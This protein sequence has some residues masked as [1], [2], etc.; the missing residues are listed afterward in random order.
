MQTTLI[1]THFPGYQNKDYINLQ[2]ILICKLTNIGDQA[3]IS[4]STFL[5]LLVQLRENRDIQNQEIKQ[6]LNKIEIN[7]LCYGRQLLAYHNSLFVRL[8]SY[9]LLKYS[10]RFKSDTSY[11]ATRLSST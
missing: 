1:L 6:I 7:Q 8:L 9:T 11:G 4:K 10:Q 3:F 5:K 2:I